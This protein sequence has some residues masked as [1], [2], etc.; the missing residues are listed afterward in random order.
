M[1]MYYH[2]PKNLSVVALVSFALLAGCNEQRELTTASNVEPLV[3]VITLTPT[4]LMFSSELPGRADPVRVAEVRARVAGIVLSRHFEEGSDV[5]AGQ[6]LFQIDPAPLKVALSRA[7]AQLANADAIL[8]EAQALVRRSQPLIKI[9]AISHQ[10]FESFQARLKI[11]QA[12]K[13]TALAD[14]A[15]ARLN[16]DYSTV[17]APISGRIG[18]AQVTEGALVGQDSATPMALIQ[19][20][21]PIYVDFQ[22][23]VVESQRLHTALANGRLT[24]DQNNGEL[25][26]I[27]LDGNGLKREGRLL[28]S[29]IS[30]DR[31]TGQMALRGQFANPDGMLQPGMYVRV[32]INQGMD[33][34][35]ILVP[36]RAV[37]RT[38]DGKASVLVVDSQHIVQRRNVETGTMKGK[39]WHIIKGLEKNEQVI[40]GGI[41]SVQPGMKVQIQE[42]KATDTFGTK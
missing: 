24:Q 17:K 5:K 30:V 25:L 1:G 37:Q 36:Q 11:A 8:T 34:S 10:E 13:M 32:N 3:D 35:A 23:P 18:R 29:D 21:D 6:V 2:W 39:Q 33:K 16:L 9:N 42:T 7:Q 28:F 40:V 38:A 4:N 19:Q 12:A 22:Q 41:A 20:L 14:V 27:T 31:D 26:S 15:T